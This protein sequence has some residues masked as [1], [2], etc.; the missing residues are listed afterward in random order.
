MVRPLPHGSAGLCPASGRPTLSGAAQDHRITRYPYITDYVKTLATEIRPRDREHRHRGQDHHRALAQ[1]AA[2]LSVRKGDR[3]E[4]RQEY[5]GPLRGLGEEQKANMLAFQK[6][7]IAWQG[8]RNS[9]STGAVVALAMKVPSAPRYWRCRQRLCLDQTSGA[10]DPKD[11]TC[12]KDMLRLCYIGGA[13]LFPGTPGTGSPGGL[14]HPERQHAGPRAAW[15]IRATNRALYAKR[16]SG[17]A[18]AVHHAAVSTGV[19]AGQHH[20]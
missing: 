15:T 18:I 3:A 5:R 2:E 12:R 11:C 7:Q 19:Y 13:W 9:S 1:D 6:N 20:P 4:M 8:L 10:W 17:S 16:Q 14:R